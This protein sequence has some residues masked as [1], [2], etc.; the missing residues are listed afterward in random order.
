MRPTVVRKGILQPN[1]GFTCCLSQL[2]YEGAAAGGAECFPIT[3][4]LL[5]ARRDVSRRFNSAG[6]GGVD[7][8]EIGAVFSRTTE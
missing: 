3:C 1:A 2:E 4:R 7:A 8:C 5:N 6:K